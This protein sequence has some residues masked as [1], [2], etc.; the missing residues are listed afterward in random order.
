MAIAASIA[1]CHGS[2]SSGESP[3]PSASVV[4][5]GVTLGTCSD[6]MQCESECDAGSADRCRRLAA[7]YALGD[8][9]EKDEAR[10]TGLYERACEMKDPP[11]CLFPWKPSH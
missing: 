8:G 7:T 11:A 10:A 5:I 1:A 6:R 3:A 9:V 2:P 4:T